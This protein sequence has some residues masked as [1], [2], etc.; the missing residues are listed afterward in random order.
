MLCVCLI[1]KEACFLI[2]VRFDLGRKFKC[3]EGS[4][5]TGKG[6][7]VVGLVVGNGVL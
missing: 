5:A 1:R 4:M 6:W 2:F 3:L 7:V